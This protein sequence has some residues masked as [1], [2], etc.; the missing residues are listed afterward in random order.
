MPRCK[1][2]KGLGSHGDR[3]NVRFCQC[4]D[5]SDLQ[6]RIPHWLE[7]ANRLPESK[8]S[9]VVQKPVDKPPVIPEGPRKPR[10]PAENE[11]ILTELI[12]HLGGNQ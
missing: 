1:I 8:K 7:L 4:P 5:G 12:T 10:D 6:R 2:C 11:K 3:P 9:T